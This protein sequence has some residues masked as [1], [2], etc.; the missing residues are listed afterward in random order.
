LYI[1]EQ[2]KVK[3]GRCLVHGIPSSELVSVPSFDQGDDER[4]SLRFVAE[5]CQARMEEIFDAVIDAVAASGF[6]APLPGGVVLTGGAASLI[7]AIELARHHFDLPARLGVP[8]GLGEGGAGLAS[9]ALAVGTGLV[10][11][12]MRNGHPDQRGNEDEGWQS[13]VR[14]LSR[15]LRHLMP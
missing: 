4:V 12:G 3:S 15:W 10:L 9:P 7:G 5:I 6:R 1:A 14:R 13:L 11:W 2:F 8:T